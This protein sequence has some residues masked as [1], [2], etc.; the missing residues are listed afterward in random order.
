MLA[1]TMTGLCD[2]VPELKAVAQMPVAEIAHRV[3]IAA[4]SAPVGVLLAAL[5][6]APTS[7]ASPAGSPGD[8]VVIQLQ[9]QKQYRGDTE[10]QAGVAYQVPPS[11]AYSWR[12]K[13]PSVSPSGGTI[14]DLPVYPG[15]GCLSGRAH[16]IEG[17]SDWACD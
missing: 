14:V 7:L 15:R 1:S 8:V 9:C 4:V 2:Y 13:R 11:D 3:G 5:L 17:T 16:P 10:F 12:C 6:M